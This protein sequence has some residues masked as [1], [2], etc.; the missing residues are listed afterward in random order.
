MKSSAPTTVHGAPHDPVALTE[1]RDL[2][3]D[4]VAMADLREAQAQ[5]DAGTTVEMTERPRPGG[6]STGSSAAGV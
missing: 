6:S 3:S 5:I 1:T 4:P 2:L